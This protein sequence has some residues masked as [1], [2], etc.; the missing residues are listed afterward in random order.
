MISA[1]KMGSMMNEQLIRR[2]KSKKKNFGYGYILRINIL[3]IS[4]VC[5]NNNYLFIFVNSL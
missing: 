4:F 1:M 2:N 5:T 3:L